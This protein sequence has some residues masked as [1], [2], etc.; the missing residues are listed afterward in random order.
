MLRACRRCL[1]TSELADAEPSD[2]ETTSA[3]SQGV[4][5]D[6]MIV[7][8]DVDHQRDVN[9]VGTTNGDLADYQVAPDPLSSPKPSN[10][11]CKNK[12]FK[13]DTTGSRTQLTFGKVRPMCGGLGKGQSTGEAQSN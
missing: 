8:V 3:G 4:G 1:G 2:L 7:N 12:S 11:F 9:V 6:Q 13:Q 10:I 5:S